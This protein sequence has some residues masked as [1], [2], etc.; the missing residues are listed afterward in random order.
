MPLVYLQSRAFVGFVDQRYGWEKVRHV[1]RETRRAGNFDAAFKTTFGM[2]TAE[3]EK[4]WKRW[5]V[6]KDEGGM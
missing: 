4:E 3:L 1:L 6:E 5:L 2:T